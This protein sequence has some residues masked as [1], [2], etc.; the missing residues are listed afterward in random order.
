[1]KADFPLEYRV[2]RG[3]RI[4]WAGFAGFCVVASLLG[5]IIVWMRSPGDLMAVL[6]LGGLFTGLSIPAALSQARSRVILTQDAIEVRGI[7]LAKR[8]ARDAIRGWRWLPMQYGAP[9][10]KVIPHDNAMPTLTVPQSL[11]TDAAFEAWFSSITNLDKDDFEESEK[12]YLAQA[13]GSQTQKRQQLDEA[14][15]NVRFLNYATYAVCAWVFFHP[16]P[17]RL[18]VSSVAILPLIAIALVAFGGPAYAFNAKKADA[19]ADA[20]VAAFLPTMALFLRALFDVSVLDQ[21]KILWMSAAGALAGAG[22]VI[23]L[24]SST[25]KPWYTPLLLLLLTGSYAYGAEALA[26]RELDTSEPEV[27]QTQVLDHHISRGKTTTYHLELGAWGPRTVR[28]EVD[29]NREY[30]ERTAVGSPVCVYL[31]RG[32]LGV[33]WFEV[34]DCASG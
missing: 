7:V 25:R 1:V 8:L 4:V 33:R 23:A 32:A 9:V 3:T 31:W 11:E 29:V 17:Y 21:E 22:L 5:V 24:V 30:Y 20:S 27:F 15:R 6:V 16:Q 18:A 28:D 14:K 34:W 10:R 13:S 2:N 26:N 19:R 12:E